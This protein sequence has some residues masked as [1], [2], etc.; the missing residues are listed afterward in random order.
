MLTEIPYDLILKINYQIRL[1]NIGKQ[2]SV[3]YICRKL[4]QHFM[5]AK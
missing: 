5:F 1:Q 4:I 2:K 3:E